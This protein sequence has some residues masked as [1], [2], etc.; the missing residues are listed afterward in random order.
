MSTINARIKKVRKDAGLNQK[1]FSESLGVTQSGV[2]YMEQDGRNVS[3]ITI[4]GICNRYNVNEDWLR[5]GTEPMYI[6]EPTFS[7]DQFVRDHQGTDLEIEIMKA[8]FELD[9]DIR[10]TVLDHFKAR[11]SAAAQAKP[12]VSEP[13][14][15]ELE[16]EYKKSVLGS[17]RNTG[18]I[19]SSTTEDTG[20]ASKA[21]NE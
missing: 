15:E 8:Y 5:Y 14:V 3:D 1:E 4:K 18:S 11:F 16:A 21:S 19:A 12:A 13:S 2:S 20:K 17:A 9:P 6:Q 7:L 10:K